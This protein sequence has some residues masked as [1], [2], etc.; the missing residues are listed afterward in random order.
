MPPLAKHLSFSF[1]RIEDPTK[2]RR[3]AVALFIIGLLGCVFASPLLLNVVS[4][5]LDVRELEQR[6]AHFLSIKDGLM[7]ELQEAYDAGKFVEAKDMASPYLDLL[8]ADLDQKY[9]VIVSTEK[10][11][12]LKDFNARREELVAS[13]KK[14]IAAKNYAAAIGV[15]SPFVDVADKEF[16]KLHDDAKNKE[17]SRQAIEQQAAEAMQGMRTA[18]GILDELEADF[19]RVPPSQVEL[20]KIRSTVFLFSVMAKNINKARHSVDAFSREDIA[21]IKKL[22]GRLVALQQRT[23]PAFRKVF[24][25]N[26]ANLLWENNLYVTVGGNA[27]TVITFS[28]GMFASN[29][30]IQ[31]FQAKLDDVLSSLRFKQSRFKWYKGADEYSYYTLKTPAD[32]KI[33]TFEAGHFYEVVAWPSGKR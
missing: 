11:E 30:N 24:A 8:D 14:S 21:Y 23:F 5:K 17:A 3:Y 25:T 33:A 13:M 12:K 7:T 6:R 28:G 19:K 1:F 20:E 29:A 22:E 15:S 31:S 18:E 10:E 9:Q 32:N 16:V 26:S 4:D 27:N 2:K